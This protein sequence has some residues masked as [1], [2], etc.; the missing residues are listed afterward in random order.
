MS[1]LVILLVLSLWV[2]LGYSIWKRLLSRLIRKPLPLLVF[3]LLFAAL[4]LIGPWVD[5]YL[6][7]KTFARLC[8]SMPDTQFL[9]PVSVGTGPFFDA[10]GNPKWTN[11]DEFRNIRQGGAVYD[12]KRGRVDR[13]GQ[14]FVNTK[15]SYRITDWP[16]P[17][18]EEKVA[19]SYKPTGQ[20][21]LISHWRGSPGG[22]LKQITGFGSNAPYQCSYRT[23]WP[24]ESKWIKY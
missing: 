22:W 24:D 12:E 2:W 19:F 9:G 4:W 14:M 8:K 15:L 13:W 21:V 7:Q 23:Q 11:K 5:E 3:T 6:G 20:L 17:I 18:I 1:A 16:V 10:Q